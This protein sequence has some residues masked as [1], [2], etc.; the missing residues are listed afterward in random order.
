MVDYSD[1]ELLQLS[2]IQHFAFCRRQWALIYIEQQWQENILTYYGR[3]LHERA[4]DPFLTEARGTVV[5]TRSMPVISRQ[6][7]LYGVADVVEFYRDEVGITI[8][9]RTGFWRP[10]PVEYK[11]GQPKPDDRDQVQLCAQA[12]CLEEML[13]VS[14][15]A[16]SLF[17]GR[18]R[19]RQPVEFDIALRKRVFALA[20]EMHELF[21]QGITP[22]AEYSPACK[23]C[24]LIEICLPAPRAKKSIRRYL[25]EAL[26]E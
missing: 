13:G 15:N 23:S 20:A 12:I 3:E 6:L 14:I 22:P 4:D 7:G 16:G 10:H 25:A 2:G 18:I 5:I 21:Q 9:G 17:Y 26:K 24:S 1:D 11:L 8:K 19:R